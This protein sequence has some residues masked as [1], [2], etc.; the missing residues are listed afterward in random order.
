MFELDANEVHTKLKKSGVDHLYHANTVRTSC[1]FFREGHL[2]SRGTLDV[3]GLDQ[4]PQYIDRNDKEFSLWYDVILWYDIF[5]DTI[6]VQDRLKRPNHYGPVLFAFSI[7]IMLE[8]WLTSVWITKSNPANWEKE[9]ISYPDR[10]FNESELH[11]SYDPVATDA[12]A[13]HIVLRNIGG[14]LRLRPHL[15]KLILDDPE[16]PWPNYENFDL[17]SMAWGALKNASRV[18]GF[19]PN[20]FK[21]E[22]RECGDLYSSMEKEKLLKGFSP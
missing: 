7:E 1:T 16:R 14:V 18:G 19:G 20:D 21:V 11:D 12:F 17:L 6:D 2:L 10:Y 3:R 5:L 4:T 13:K 22:T 15:A 8:D 9:N